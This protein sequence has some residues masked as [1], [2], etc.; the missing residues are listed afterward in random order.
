M[1]NPFFPL[2]LIGRK[3]FPQAASPIGK[4]LRFEIACFLSIILKSLKA[5]RSSVALRASWGPGCVIPG[6]VKGESIGSVS[7]GAGSCVGA[8]GSLPEAAGV[9]GV[10][11]LG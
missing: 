9:L 2:G 11:R 8:A 10:V 5:P 3:F 4:K 7:D 1:A 6:W